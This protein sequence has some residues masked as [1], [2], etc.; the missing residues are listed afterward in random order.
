MIYMHSW[1]NTS[2]KQQENSLNH[3]FRLKFEQTFKSVQ[4]RELHVLYRIVEIFKGMI[5]RKSR[6]ITP[7]K[8]RADTGTWGVCSEN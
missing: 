5:Y 7:V 4:V 6:E 8:A 3:G 2:H 1:D